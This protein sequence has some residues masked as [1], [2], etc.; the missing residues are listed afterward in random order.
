MV[1]NKLKNIKYLLLF[2][3][4]FGF[5]LLIKKLSL[6]LGLAHLNDGI[7][8]GFFDNVY[9]IAVLI[10]SGIVSFYYLF[11]KYKTKSNSWVILILAGLISN[12]YDRLFYF[13][14]IDYIN[15]F[16]LIYFNLADLF[17][18]FGVLLFIKQNY[19]SILTGQWS[20]PIV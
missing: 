2:L 20:E 16:G 3:V 7:F 11:K 14:V 5:E 9:L 8:F 17:I 12:L 6:D 10:L 4:L 19:N 13:A 15:F 18:I 1:R